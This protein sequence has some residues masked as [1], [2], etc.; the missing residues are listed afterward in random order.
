MITE[1]LEK[2]KKLQINHLERLQQILTN[3]EQEQLLV[4]HNATHP[5]ETIETYGE[6]LSDKVAKFGGSWKFI[7]VFGIILTLWIIFNVVAN[8]LIFDPYPF[9]LMNLILSCIAALQAP[10]IMMSQNRQEIKD[11]KRNEDDYLSELKSNTQIHSL[12]EKLNLLIEDQF[13]MVYETQSKQLKMLDE[14]NT[15]IEAMGKK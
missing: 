12:N 4:V 5:E 15:K 8:Y 13:K 10:V 9:I 1:E 3:T 2:L 7:I 14:I 11:R 6:K